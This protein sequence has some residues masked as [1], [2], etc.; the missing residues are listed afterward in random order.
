MRWHYKLFFF[1]CSIDNA[2]FQEESIALQ[3]FKAQKRKELGIH[4]KSS[5][6]LYV[7]SLTSRKRCIDLIRAFECLDEF[8]AWLV[9]VGDG[10]EKLTLMGYATMNRLDRIIFV[11]FKNQGEICHIKKL[12]TE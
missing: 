6:I 1:P 5:V 4:P 7:G 9:L 12:N 11:G 8:G 3:A 10:S 2:F